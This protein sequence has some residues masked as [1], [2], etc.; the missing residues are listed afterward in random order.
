MG[1]SHT[2]SLSS[3]NVTE[4]TG[5]GSWFWYC[6]CLRC[7]LPSSVEP[8]CVDSGRALCS[9]LVR[10]G[11][12]PSSMQDPDVM[13]ESLPTPLSQQPQ[14][15]GTLCHSQVWSLRTHQ[16][17]TFLWFQWPCQALV[18]TSLCA[19]FS[20]FSFLSAFIFLFMLFSMVQFD[21]FADFPPHLFILL[22]ALKWHIKILIIYGVLSNVHD[23]QL[24]VSLSSFQTYIISFLYGKHILD[25]FF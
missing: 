24:R 14:V 2:I 18:V 16:C 10:H 6:T 20:F 12:Q 3:M 13:L 11:L 21:K 7:K 25:C 8:G 5:Y 19:Y 1:P 23:I 15:G 9:W 4:A 17:V 22:P